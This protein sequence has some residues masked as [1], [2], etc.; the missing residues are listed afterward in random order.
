MVQEAGRARTAGAVI[1]AAGLAKRAGGPKAVWPVEGVP[2]VRRAAQAA[3][4]AEPVAETAGVVG[5]PW[6]GAV[7]KALEGLALKVAE[8]ENFASGQSSSR[9]AGPGSMNFAP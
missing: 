1:L 7:K 3:L 8:N 5:G 9:K 4:G 2:S 6:A